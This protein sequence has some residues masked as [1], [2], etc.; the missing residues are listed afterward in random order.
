MY[1]GVTLNRSLT[2]KVSTPHNILQKL[3]T[4]KWAVTS[5]V[6]RTSALALSYS[7]AD[8][9]CP[10]WEQS[11]HTKRLDPV[12]NESYR[13]ITGC[14]KPTDADNL[15]L[16][17]GAAPPENQR[18]AASKLERSSQAYDPNHMLFNHRP[19]PSRLKSRRSF[20]LC[21]EPLKEK[22]FNLERNESS[23]RCHKAL[24]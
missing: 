15:H 20:L 19:V 1:L 8:Y 24:A 6:L 21:V 4:S 5:H 13:L 23:K 7:A 22:N 17:A 18:E 14:L 11:A 3:A 2:F 12:P 16:L 9:A 10:I